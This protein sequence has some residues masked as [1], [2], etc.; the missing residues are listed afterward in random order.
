MPTDAEMN[1]AAQ[2]VIRDIWGGDIT[3]M[4]G[5]VAPAPLPQPEPVGPTGDK[6]CYGTTGPGGNYGFDRYA[7][8]AQ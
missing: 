5:Y 6:T 1:Q 7:G 3:K 8:Y 4:P 2:D